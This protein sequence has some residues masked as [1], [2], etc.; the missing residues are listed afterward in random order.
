MV[1]RLISAVFTSEHNVNSGET[2]VVWNTAKN[3]FETATAGE[4]ITS[5]FLNPDDAE[6]E[7]SVDER[8]FAFLYA[9]TDSWVWDFTEVAAAAPQGPSQ[10]TTYNPITI[11]T[12]PPPPSSQNPDPDPVPDSTPLET[13]I[14]SSPGGDYTIRDYDLTITLANPNEAGS[15]DIYY[16]VN[17]GSWEKYTSGTV[18]DI[19]PDTQ[20]ATQAIAANE[21]FTDGSSRILMGGYCR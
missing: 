21:F 5:F 12:N 14:F 7:R 11:V 6:I 17:Y 20:I 9:G 18:I 16:Q 1:D 10:I 8:D 2:R 4:G 19:E 3:A 15:S 13:P